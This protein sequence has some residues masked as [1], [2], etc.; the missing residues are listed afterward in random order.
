MIPPTC[1]GA[2]RGQPFRLRTLAF[3]NV[4]PHREQ[5]AQKLKRRPAFGTGLVLHKDVE[6]ERFTSGPAVEADEQIGD[7]LPKLGLDVALNEERKSRSETGSAIGGF[8]LDQEYR[9]GCADASITGEIV[10][11]EGGFLLRTSTRQIELFSVSRAIAV[12]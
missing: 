12:Q 11:G 5:V 3:E 7:L 10:G 9:R 1:R 8:L 4:P 2:Y 6:V